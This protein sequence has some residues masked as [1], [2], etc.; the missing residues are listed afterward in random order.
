MLFFHFLSHSVILYKM[1]HFVTFVV[2][3]HLFFPLW[4]STVFCY[5]S[6]YIIIEALK[7]HFFVI[8]FLAF[9][10]FIAQIAKT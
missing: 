7:L 2:F 1:S 10:I 8:V 9:S 3:S 4:L 5:V 6:I